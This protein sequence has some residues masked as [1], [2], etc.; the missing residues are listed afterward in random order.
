MYSSKLHQ[1]LVLQAFCDE[2][3]K[4]SGLEKTANPATWLLK[5]LRFA[6]KTSPGKLLR[7]A[8]AAALKKPSLMQRASGEAY[9]NT[10]LLFKN[11][12]QLLKE[13]LFSARHRTVAAKKIK[14]GQ[15][16]TVFG[17]KYK[18]KGY[19]RKGQAVIKRNPLGMATL[20]F[21]TTGLGMGGLELATNKTDQ[22]GR[23]QSMGKRLMGAGTQAAL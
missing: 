12:K 9:R 2:L 17:K 4:T 13:Q 5:G 20:G 10:R 6:A 8:P 14:N 3:Q 22:Y 15:Y 19:N 21:G 7:H 18:V 23:S 1:R 16:K 11:P